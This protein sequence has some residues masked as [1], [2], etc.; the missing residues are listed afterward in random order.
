MKDWNAVV[1][2]NV[3]GLREAFSVLQQHGRLEKTG[4]FNVLALTAR[5]VPAMLDELADMAAHVPGSLDF[6]SRLIPV[7][8]TFTFRSPDE[9]ERKATD[10]AMR[11]VPV[12]AGKGF[13]VRM[14]R[15]GFKGKLSSQTEEQFLDRFLLEALERAGTPGHITFEHPDAVVVVE[16]IAGWAGLTLLQSEELARYPFMRVEN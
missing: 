12:L 3:R 15:R 11:W 8:E 4:F 16:T 14:R 9:F 6:L 2:I 13:F 1:C 10:V 7:S 5:D